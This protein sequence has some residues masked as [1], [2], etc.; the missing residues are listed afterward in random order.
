MRGRPDLNRQPH[1]RQACAPPIELRP[2][3]PTRG[4]EP[5]TDNAY[6]AS[7]LTTELRRPIKCCGGGICTTRPS[8]YGPDELLLLYPAANDYTSLF[9]NLQIAKS[10][11]INL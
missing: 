5:L 9:Q 4:F 6:E 3:V 10:L 11:L 2:Q 7:A 1:A 8:G